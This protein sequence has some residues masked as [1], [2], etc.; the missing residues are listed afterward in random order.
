MFSVEKKNCKLNIETTKKRTKQS[1][2]SSIKRNLGCLTKRT[3][4]RAK[5]RDTL[6][7][8]Q[9]EEQSKR[10]NTNKR[11]SYYNREIPGFTDRNY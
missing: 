3:N 4:Q 5:V 11:E 6:G 7:Q 8:G 10:T 1:F 2:Q 9:S